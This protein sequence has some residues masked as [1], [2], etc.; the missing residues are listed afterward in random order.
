MDQ[1]NVILNLEDAEERGLTSAILLLAG[2]AI[3]SIKNDS[4]QA[5][6]KLGAQAMVEALSVHESGELKRIPTIR[7]IVTQ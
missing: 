5:D 4:N 7:L 6:P 1:G 3:N 2:S